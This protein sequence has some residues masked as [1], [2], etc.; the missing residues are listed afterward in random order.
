VGIEI[1]SPTSSSTAASPL[2]KNNNLENWTQYSVKTLV[3]TDVDASN[4]WWGTTDTHVI[5]QSIYDQRYDFN[6][7]QV[8]FQPILPSPDTSAPL[9]PDAEI[10]PIPTATPTPTETSI[11]SIVNTHYPRVPNSCGF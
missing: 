8:N 3:S 9:T 7:G 1:Q 5:E 4:N 6:L 2:I 10:T 11:I